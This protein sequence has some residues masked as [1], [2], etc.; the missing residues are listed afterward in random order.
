MNAPARIG[1]RWWLWLGLALTL[2]KFWL[3]QAQPIFA[4]GNA[5]LDD[6]LFLELAQALVRGDWL[7]AYNEATLAKGPGYPLF[8]ALVFYIGLPLGL[9]QHAL[10][11]GACALFARACR[12]ALPLGACCGI[13]LLLLWN[14]MSYEAAT[15][16][17]IMRQ[18]LATPLGLIMFASLVALYLRRVE[19][20]QR[21]WPWAML[22][23]ISTGLFW[24]TRE[25][26][27]WILPSLALLAGSF[28]YG[29]WQHTWQVRRVALQAMALAAITALL[30]ST[31]VSWQ[32][33]RNYGWFG[34]VE[35]KAPEFRAAYGALQRIKAT[36]DLVQVPV[37]RQAREL[38]YPLSPT[39]AKLRP[40]LESEAWT[41]PE[42]RLEQGRQIRGG[43][44][45]WALRESVARSGHAPDARTAL[46]FYRAL[47]DELNAL[48][49][50]GQL[51]AW[52]R[53]DSLVPRWHEGQP[54]AV[55]RSVLW[56][57]DFVAGFTSFTPYTPLSI[58]DREEL[59][60]FHDLTGNELSSSTR[61]PALERPT[62]E[63]LRDYKLQVLL[64]I[65][66]HL[67]HALF[68]VCGVAHVCFALRIV[69]CLRQRR[70]T[71]PLLLACAAWGGVASFLVINALVHVLSF[72]LIAVSTFGPV[73]PLLLVFY[74]AVAWDAANAWFE[75]EPSAA[76]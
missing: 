49:D 30:P 51:P 3:T 34:T 42:L 58:G 48:C 25:E 64:Q 55:V 32:N 75:R 17:R 6:R 21:L 24:L 76:E 73:Y 74:L 65:G 69:Q 13:Y 70:L 45:L 67:A 14:P 43:W 72:P 38:A 4:I 37:T 59:K 50:S 35:V 11:A 52:P 2:I 20:W 26:S 33:Y 31:L 68:V 7:G 57:A 44:F 46:Q 29:A 60:L 10:Y 19:S 8:V 56:F 61:A 62:R 41:D 1:P 71:Y 27:I 23:G 53:R 12:P 28:L 22:L 15:L 36:P 16:G 47:A 9:A 5:T 54:A 63:G 39:L 66:S 40:W 18:H